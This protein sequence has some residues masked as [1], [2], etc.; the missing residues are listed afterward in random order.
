MTSTTYHA[1]AI[2]A[3]FSIVCA[4]I[5]LTAYLFFLPEMRKSLVG[6]ISC[7]FI[8]LGIAG[9]QFAHYLFFVFGSDVLEF[10]WYAMLL[11]LL[12]PSFFIFA[13][14]VIFPDAKFRWVDILHFTPL[15][16]GVFIS[17]NLVP[18]LAFLLG[19]IYTF[20]IVR[21]VYK[22]RDQR[23]R[24]KVELFFFGMFAFMALFALILGLSLPFIDHRF[25]YLFYA[26]SISIAMASVMF[27]LLIFPELLSDIVMITELAYAKSKLSG[28]NTKI[29]LEQLEKMMIED[30]HFENEQLSLSMV[31]ELLELTPHQLSELINT[32]YG[33]SF[34]RFVREHRIR[35][36]K[37]LLI[38]QPD[39]S[40]LAIS[41]MTGFKSQSNFYAAFKEATGESPGNFRQNS[42]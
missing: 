10:H 34:P 36:A 31:A 5:L 22:I 30:K 16:L 3:G 37:T 13:R 38:T 15:L 20:W 40:V 41:M 11:L 24:F 26:N 27:A 21:I 29:K 9:L 8:Q 6:K 2:L 42:N 7:C 39:I 19:T 35:A 14:A 33:F 17:L 12:P 23:S 32:E 28:V 18:S 1:S 25:F 4:L